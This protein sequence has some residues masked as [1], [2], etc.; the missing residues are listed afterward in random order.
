MS[1]AYHMGGGNQTQTRCKLHLLAINEKGGERTQRKRGLY[2]RPCRSLLLSSV[3]R[4]K[5]IE[6]LMVN[7]STVVKTVALD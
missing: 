3:L 4:L 1:Q 6:L 5:T 2:L 7:T